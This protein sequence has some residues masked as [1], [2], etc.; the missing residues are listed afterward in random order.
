MI[1]EFMMNHSWGVAT[2][3]IVAAFLLIDYTNREDES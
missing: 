3:L 1:I 2:A